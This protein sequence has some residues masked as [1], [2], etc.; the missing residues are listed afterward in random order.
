[1]TGL[2]DKPIVFCFSFDAANF[3]KGMKQTSFGYKIANLINA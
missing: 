1:M 3:H 2:D